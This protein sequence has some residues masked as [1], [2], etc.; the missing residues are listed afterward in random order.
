L[1]HDIKFTETSVK[2]QLNLS[3]D[4]RKLKSLVEAKFQGIDKKVEIS[5]APSTTKTST[6]QTKLK[7]GLLKVKN[8][9]AVSSCKGGVGKSTIAVNLSYALKKVITYSR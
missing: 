6:E 3:K 5:M 9:I 2:I 8:I 1:V 4:Y 7:P